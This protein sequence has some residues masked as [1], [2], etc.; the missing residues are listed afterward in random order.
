MDNRAFDLNYDKDRKKS[1]ES[2]INVEEGITFAWTKLNVS[3][4]AVAES[5]VAGLVVR[6]EKSAK[7][8]LREVTGIARPGEVL[9]IMGASGAGKSSLLNTFLFRYS[10]GLDISGTRIA[11]GEVVT[12]TNL[13]SVSA[14]VQQ[15]D[16]FI[17]S[18]SVKE[19]LVFQSRV[20][21]DKHL[22]SKERLERVEDVMRQVGLKKCE[23]TLIGGEKLKGISGGE[24]KRLSFAS[25]VLTNPAILFCDEPTSGLDSF[26]A[27]SIMELMQS[28]ART[29]KTIICTIH[30]PSSQ[31]FNKFDKLL[32][33]AE[34][35][36]AYL[37]DAKDC[38]SFFAGAN[39]PCPEDFNPADHFV[40]TLA[41][42]PGSEEECHQR[43]S[44]ICDRF[45]ESEPAQDIRAEIKSIE[46]QM[47][48]SDK[49]SVTRREV[50]KASWGEQFA[51]LAWRQSLAVIKDPMIARVKV[52]SA[53][54]VGIILG[55]IYQAQDM[56]QAGIQN[57]NGALF[58]I[59]TNLSFGNIFSIC[60]S[61]CSELPVFL[62]EH[63][64]GMYRTDAFFFAK[65]VVEMPL[66]IL[67]ATIMFTLIYW[68]ANLNPEA[69]RF[70]IALG[71][72]IL[73]LQVVF[74]LG[75][76][77]SCTLPTV[78]IALAIAPVLIIPMMLFGGFYLNSSS[79]VVWLAWIKYISWFY[80]GF[81]A[82]LVNQWS[83]VEGIK[84]E[85]E[86]MMSRVMTNMTDT[87]TFS[88][89]MAGA[90][91]ITTGDQVLENIGFDKDDFT[92]N[93]LLLVVL[94]V[95]L[96]LLA[97]L[98]LLNKTRRK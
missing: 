27:L 66:Y 87:D 43:I 41:V 69:E 68:I 40:Q 4:K 21:M 35:Q 32:L 89:N 97:F 98:A 26:M 79:V 36:T 62:R 15:E 70:F 38:K 53:I 1:M 86:K 54:V 33:M 82:L 60:N 34:G 48:E 47:A 11:D 6:Q 72:I 24:K 78:D 46:N 12:P 10:E 75:Y 3:T 63:F 77:L 44:E 37:G 65:Q 19:H 8:I 59:V 85:T 17:P 73:I 28:L 30:Q 7:R 64:N 13:T 94:A 83:G 55:T 22:S 80:Y 61:Y 49:R 23:N 31:V 56:D 14:Y 91:C 90:A 25:E 67:E 45:R 58:V 81:S 88:N 29:G 93:I 92:R 18:L 52:I 5:K 2:A 16:L 51:A 74:S 9:A 96:R 57:I 20:R 76:F 42:V 84:C 39:Y 50:Y 95:V 71:I